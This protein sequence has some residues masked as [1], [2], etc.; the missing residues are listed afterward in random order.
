MEKTCLEKPKVLCFGELLLRYEAFG[1]NLFGEKFGRF[2][3]SPGGSEANVAVKLRAL[4][5]NC[6]F[7]SAV[8][9]NRISHSALRVLMEHEVDISKVMYTGARIGIYYL[10][11]ANGLSTGDVIYDRSFSSFSQL[12]PGDV[13]WENVFKNVDWF[14]FSAIT[15]SLNYSLVNV[16]KEGLEYAQSCDITIS[17]DLNYRNTLWKYGKKPIDVMPEL[18]SYADVV[19]GNVWAAEKMLEVN[20]LKGIG[21]DSQKAQLIEASE[22]CSQQIFREYGKCKHIANTFRFMD[23]DFH[24]SFFGVYHNRV[25]TKFSET[26][27]SNKVIDRIGSGD[28]FMAGV[29]TGIRKGFSSQMIVDLATTSGFEKLFVKGDF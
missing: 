7:F 4:G 27:E 8:P 24:N 19:M 29:I 5:E 13:D 10:L 1:N 14:H 11:S 16:L 28:A 21:R 25:G 23:N 9:E 17:V 12:R 6:Y 15:P 2:N 20:F 18:V 26:L 22:L 3:V